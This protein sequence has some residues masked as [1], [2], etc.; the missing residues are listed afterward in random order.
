LAKPPAPD[1]A[2]DGVSE[3]ACVSIVLEAAM[4]DIDDV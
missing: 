3:K 2:P 4:R 1:K